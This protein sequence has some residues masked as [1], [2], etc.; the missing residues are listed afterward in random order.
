MSASP[1][2]ATVGGKRGVLVND[3]ESG[4]VWEAAVMIHELVELIE[5]RSAG[6][7]L[8]VKCASGTYKAM[9]RRWWVL[10]LGEELLV[11]IALERTVAA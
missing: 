7:L 6:S 2:E 5:A 9:A 8:E 3:E 1:N 4:L 10:P 11:R